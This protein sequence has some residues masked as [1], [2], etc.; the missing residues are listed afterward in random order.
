VASGGQSALH[1]G[2]G[3]IIFMKFHSMTSSCLFNR[4]TTFSQTV[5]YH[6]TVWCEG[7]LPEFSQTCPKKNS[8][9]VTSKQ[10]QKLFMSFWAPFFSNRT[11]LGAIFAQIFK[12]FA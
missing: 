7:F 3:A 6:T 5:T 9:N 10:K 12:E 1:F 11:M 2:G 4:G 8:K